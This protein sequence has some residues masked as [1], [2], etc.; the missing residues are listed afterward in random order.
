MRKL[1]WTIAFSSRRVKNRSI[2]WLPASLSFPRSIF[3]YIYIAV[4]CKLL[5]VIGLSWAVNWKE[6]IT[7]NHRCWP[8]NNCYLREKWKLISISYLFS[9]IASIFSPRLLTTFAFLWCIRPVSSSHH[10]RL[11]LSEEENNWINNQ[12]QSV[13]SA[14]ESVSLR[15]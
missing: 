15:N 10:R 13:C 1:K 2:Q 5:L 11:L 3:L 12:F 4:I 8:F 7:S 6:A 14:C 9:S